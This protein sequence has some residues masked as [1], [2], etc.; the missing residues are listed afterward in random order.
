MLSQRNFI[1]PSHKN[2]KNEIYD[3]ND[4]EIKLTSKILLNKFKVRKLTFVK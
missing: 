4:N 3:G 2:V 1:S